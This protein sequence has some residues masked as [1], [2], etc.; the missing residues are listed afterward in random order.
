MMAEVKIFTPEFELE[1]LILIHDVFY[2]K[3]VFFNSLV[4]SPVVSKIVASEYH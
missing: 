4:M 3:K 2:L 1:I